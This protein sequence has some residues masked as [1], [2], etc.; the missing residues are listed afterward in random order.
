MDPQKV[1]I[2]LPYLFI[3]CLERAMVYITT[4]SY[5]ENS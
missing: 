5:C 2:V 1:R 3:V 4:L